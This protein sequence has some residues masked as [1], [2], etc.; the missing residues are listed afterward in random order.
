MSAV[1]ASF[2]PAED[3]LLQ[4]TLLFLLFLSLL[5]LGAFND[6]ALIDPDSAMLRTPSQVPLYLTAV[7]FAGYFVCFGVRRRQSVLGMEHQM[8][9]LFV[10]WMLASYVANFYSIA[11][12]DAT[13]IAG[14]RVYLNSMRLIVLMGACCTIF[15]YVFTDRERVLDVASKAI[16]WSFI[17]VIPYTVI[18]FFAVFL[19]YEPAQSLMQMLDVYLHARRDDDYTGQIFRLRG[20][21]FEP[22]FFAAYLSVV[23]PWLL[24]AARKRGFWPK[25]WVALA[26]AFALL[27][28][29]RTAYVVILLELLLFYFLVKKEELKGGWISASGRILLMGL[30]IA[31]VGVV[32]VSSD[33]SGSDASALGVAPDQVQEVAGTFS[34]LLDESVTSNITRVGSQHAALLMALD[35]PVFG[36][37]MGMSGAH[38]EHYYPIYFY[39]SDEAQLWL[40]SAHLDFSAATFGLFVGIAA[41]LGLVGLA[42]FIALWG[43][44]LKRI[45]QRMLPKRGGRELEPY[46]LALFVSSIGTLTAGFGLNG[47][48]FTGYWL[49]LALAFIYIGGRV[50]VPLRNRA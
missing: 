26:L 27:S 39:A 21:A 28:R 50:E 2:G 34:S 17:V 30:V 7:V 19:Y 47:S 29:S 9:A 16:V 23:L 24:A 1:A 41:E 22:S 15:S 3:R 36:V 13:I 37:G 11:T 40:R 48:S 31:V 44:C 18:E 20:L 45:Y 5:F 4:K 43:V 14:M 49:L 12:T 35:N 32:A 42:I 38:I 46:G 10:F 8:L 33:I 6:F 25:V